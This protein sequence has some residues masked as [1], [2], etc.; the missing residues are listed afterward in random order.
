M[1]LFTL[2]PKLPSLFHN[3]GVQL[4]YC[5]QCTSLQ[6]GPYYFQ[7][8]EQYLSWRHLST[9]SAFTVLLPLRAF[10]LTPAVSQTDLRFTSHACWAFFLAQQQSQ[11]TDSSNKTRHKFPY[12]VHHCKGYIYP[13]L[14]YGGRH[15]SSGFSLTMTNLYTWLLQTTVPGLLFPVLA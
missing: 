10:S 15:I 2:R 9:A 13:F 11:C 7:R 14:V 12:A 6:F 8:T 1:K 4:C 5:P 3:A